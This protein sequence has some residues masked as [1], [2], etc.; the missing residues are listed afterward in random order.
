MSTGGVPG[1]GPQEGATDAG[2]PTGPVP[3]ARDT[4]RLATASLVCGI[5]WPFCVTAVLAI[6]FGHR[7]LGQIARAGGAPRGRGQALAGLWLGYLGLGSIVA[8]VIV[9]SLRG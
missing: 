9:T 1:D 5:L 4:N 2:G 8:S 7:A 6:I 3:A